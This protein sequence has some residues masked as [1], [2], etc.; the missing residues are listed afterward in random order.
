[1]QQCSSRLISNIVL[2]DGADNE[3]LRYRVQECSSESITDACSQGRT[4][5][6]DVVCTQ[7]VDDSNQRYKKGVDLAR[8]AVV[9]KYPDKKLM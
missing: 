1:M 3:N 7:G 9:Y 4:R 2:K 6:Q 8:A 5:S